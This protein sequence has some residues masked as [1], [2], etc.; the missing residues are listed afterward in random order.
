MYVYILFVLIFET[1]QKSDVYFTKE[2]TP[3]KVVEIFQKLNVTLGGKIGLKVHTGEKDGPYFLRPSFL[4]NIY[5]YTGGTFIETNTAYK[6]DRTTTS[7][8]LE[9]LETN[10]W[11]AYRTVIMDEDET[12]DISLS[13]SN[14]NMISEN[15]VGQHLLEYDSS[16]VLAHFKGHT[17]GGFGGAL[18]Q[19]SIGFASRAGKTYIH[20]AGK[21]KDYTQIW[22]NTANQLNFTASMAD[23]ASSIVQYFRSKGGIAYINV[24]ANISVS[25]D[26]T[27]KRAAV[28]KIRDIGI[29]ASLDPVAID[30]ACYDLIENE[31]TE[32]SEDWKK[33][34]DNKLGLNTLDMAEILGIGN[35]DYNLIKIDEEPSPQETEEEENKE[36]KKEESKDEKEEENESKPETEVEQEEEYEEKYNENE[37]EYEREIEAEKEKE[38]EEEKNHLTE[39]E[40]KKDTLVLQIL[41]PIIAVI[42]IIVIIFIITMVKKK[43][44]NEGRLINEEIGQISPD[45]KE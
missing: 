23:A 38:S 22:Q 36:E 13:I 12:Q 2:I 6:G 32:G 14:Y 40:P 7:S 1:F 29:L 3:E 25:C 30:K 16:L 19:L 33:R 18:K 37:E 21:T 41:I 43:K 44:T 39:E 17:M 35:Q 34:A 4:K 15:F 26:C 28:P 5:E 27:G 8:H 45:V 42:I 9:T 11:T 24:L 20:T 10:G 31:H